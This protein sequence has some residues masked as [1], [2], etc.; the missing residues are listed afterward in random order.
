MSRVCVNPPKLFCYICGQ[1]T[2]KSEKKPI[3]PLLEK[4]YQHY[5]KMPMKNQDKSWVPSV[6]CSKCYKYLTGWYNGTIKKM[7][8]GVPMQWREPKNHIDDCYF[9]L[10]DVHGFSK[11]SKHS[12]KYAKVSS[13]SMPISHSP[14]IPIPQPPLRSP[15]ATEVDSVSEPSSQEEFEVSTTT[16]P[17]LISQSDLNDLVRDLDLTKEKSEI[18]G[19]RLKQWNLLQTDVNTTA[20][21]KRHIS[22]V[23]FYSKENSLVFCNNI[24][25]LMSALGHNHQPEQW[26]L[27]IDGSKLSLK[28]VLL[29]NGNILP[30]LPVAYGTHLKETYDILK[31]ILEKINYATYKWKICADLKVVAL[32]LGLQTGYTKYC[33]F[34]CQ[35][36]SRARTDHYIK[37]NWCKRNE[38]IPGQ[39]NVKN[40]P[41]VPPDKIILPPLHI[42]L[43]LIKNFVKALPRDG[44]AFQFLKTK[45]PTLSEAKIKEG[46]FVGPDVR[47]LIKDSTFLSRLSSVE[48]EAW[49]AFV[50][51]TKNFLGNHK[52][53]DFQEKITVM[54]NAY[55]KLGCNM[56]LKIHFLHSHLSFFPENMGAVS[57][58]HGERFHQEISEFEKRYQGKWEPTM[59]ADYCWSL[60]RETDITAHRRKAKRA[61]KLPFFLQNENLPQ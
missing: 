4:C 29:H 36:D 33:C 11:K 54:L 1:F 14:D 25:G 10:T 12:V 21:R 6:C 8:F 32:I 31:L 61:R 16:E 2:P 43:G 5:F 23:T 15:S 44:P 3:S 53:P 47:K 46:I 37:Q 38:F 13:V 20:Y 55:H 51:V 26:R 39:K 24:D 41:L 57:D 52:S 45:F 35:W 56:S 27:F 9:C 59:L 30:S 42:K 40:N 18:L 50:D 17:H 48:M 49:L 22:L 58:E 34:L 60:Q 7:P 28:A 19:S